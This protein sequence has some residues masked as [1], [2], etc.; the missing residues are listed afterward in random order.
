MPDWQYTYIHNGVLPGLR[1]RGVT[2]EQIEQMLITQPAG[3]LRAG[4]AA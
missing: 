3:V 4:D 2:E 1:D